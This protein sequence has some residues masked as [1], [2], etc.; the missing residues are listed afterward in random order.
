MNTSSSMGGLIDSQRAARNSAL[1]GYSLQTLRGLADKLFLL[2]AGYLG[3]SYF[4]FSAIALHWQIACLLPFV[5][6]IQLG[7]ELCMA[8]F[9][10]IY[11]QRVSAHYVRNYTWRVWWQSVRRNSFRRLEQNAFI[12]AVTYVIL[13]TPAP[14]IFVLMSPFIAM[15]A[16]AILPWERSIIEPDAVSH[17]PCADQALL[18]R[19]DPML[20]EVGLTPQA[21]KI[22][23]LSEKFTMA[24]AWKC[25]EQVWLGDTLLSKCSDDAVDSVVGH[26]I[27]HYFHKHS[28]DTSW[29]VQVHIWLALMVGFLTLLSYPMFDADLFKGW[30]G[31]VPVF[32]LAY[33]LT[34][35]I[36][37]RAELAISRRHEREADEYALDKVGAKG[38]RDLRD[39]LCDAN[40]HWENPWPILVWLFS[41]HPSTAQRNAH[42]DEWERRPKRN[43]RQEFAPACVAPVSCLDIARVPCHVVK[44]AALSVTPTETGERK[45]SQ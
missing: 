36:L 9:S 27:G 16:Y 7:R 35:T 3:A 44:D 28:D 6:L 34:R 13:I 43:R 1:L 24:N 37:K 12:V 30:L 45:T 15:M 33:E 17:V 39:A 23:N 41:T 25:G 5:F 14:F 10:F 4:D 21:V 29:W 22:A 2:L 31:A 20:K 26:E 19:I 40:H 8:P 32:M 42:I 18:A 11:H 38:A